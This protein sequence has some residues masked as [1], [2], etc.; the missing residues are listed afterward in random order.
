MIVLLCRPGLTMGTTAPKL[1]NKMQGQEVDPRGGRSHEVTPTAKGMV[2]V[3][4]VMDS[5][6]M[7]VR[8]SDSHRPMALAN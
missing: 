2:G 5:R 7:A 3:L 8:Q 6:V 4:T 1:G